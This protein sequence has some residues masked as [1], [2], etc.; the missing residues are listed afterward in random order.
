MDDKALSVGDWATIVTLASRGEKTARELAEMFGV[1]VQAIHQGLN[2]R[3]V[4][5]GSAVQNVVKEVE[6]EAAAARK[7]KVQDAQKKAEDYGKYLDIVVQLTVK[8][9]TDANKNNGAISTV[10]AD[11][12]TLKNAMAIIAKGRQENWAVHKIDELLQENEDLAELN[13]GEYTED[14]LEAIREANEAAFQESLDENIDEFI[15]DEDED[16]EPIEPAD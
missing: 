5:F 11:V 12:I 10:N 6:D 4:K 7:K 14:E 13:V 15:L 9:V 3:G 8:K 2:K 16:Q 1:S